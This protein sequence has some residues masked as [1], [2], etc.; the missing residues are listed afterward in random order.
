M[1][2]KALPLIHH[3]FEEHGDGDGEPAQCPHND[4]SLFKIEICV[5][6]ITFGYYTVI[7]D[8]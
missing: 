4:C 6:T 5:Y 8:V 3:G 1:H 7:Y 2:K